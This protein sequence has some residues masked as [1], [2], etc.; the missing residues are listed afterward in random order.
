MKMTETYRPSV[1]AHQH[2]HVQNSTFVKT[3][4]HF[5]LMDS[6]FQQSFIQDT[7]SVPTPDASSKTKRNAGGNVEVVSIV[8]HITD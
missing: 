1:R 4:I 3:Q 8:K 6:N 7:T 5:L 2:H